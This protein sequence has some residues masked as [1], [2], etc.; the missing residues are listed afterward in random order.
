[1][2]LWSKIEGSVWLP[3]QLL[4]ATE[5]SNCSAGVRYSSLSRTP[6]LWPCRGHSR[7]ANRRQTM[8]C[9][10]Q[11]SQWFDHPDSFHSH[12][13]CCRSFLRKKERALTPLSKG[14]VTNIFQQYQKYQP[15]N[16]ISPDFIGLASSKSCHCC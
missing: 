12:R 8:D 4:D 14:N 10:K 1:M 9:H 15:Y 11:D 16:P 6:S 2:S 5:A 13:L 3:F 7:F